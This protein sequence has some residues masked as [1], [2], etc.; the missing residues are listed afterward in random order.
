MPVRIFNGRT[1]A[2]FLAAVFAM[3]ILGCANLQ[4]QRGHYEPITAELKQENFAAAAQKME[5]AKADGKFPGKDRLLYYLDAGLLYYYAGDFDSSIERLQTAEQSS[6]DLFTKSISRAALSVLLNDNVLEYA[7]EDY[8]ILYTN[9][10]CALAYMEKGNVEDAFVEIRRA[11][12]KL[13]LLEQ[14]YNDAARVLRDGAEKDTAQVKIDYEA[15][16]I[17]FNNDA[18]ARWLSMHLYAQAGKYDDARIDHDLLREAFLTQ[19]HI[20]DFPTPNVAYQADSGKAILSVA[21]FL[22]LAPTKEGFALRIRTDKQLGLVQVLYT[23]TENKDQEYG[24]LPI[25]VKADYYFKFAIPRIVARPST[26]AKV[27]VSIGETQ[28]G[29]LAMLEDVSS[30]AKETFEA[31][32]SL[33]YLRSIARAVAKGL[34]THQ[35]KKKADDGG[36]TGWLKKAAI[37]VAADATEAADLRSSQYLPGKIHVADF[38][39]AP[40]TYDVTLTFLASNGTVVEKKVIPNVAVRP[41]GFNLVQAFSPK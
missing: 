27:Q 15:K 22:G 40:G 8:E 19:P 29:E 23:D 34:T 18:F 38:Q 9:L 41:G 35:A 5:A 16:K 36:L 26:I 6:E 39:I 21:G 17:K 1:V 4:T 13:E 33:I 31:K 25:P 37:D 24:H 20:Y 32:K 12:L 14:K 7:G 2:L 10:I 11:N 3:S 30:V 28:L